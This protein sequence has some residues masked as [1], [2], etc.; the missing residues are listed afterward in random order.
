MDHK[1]V[2]K[3]TIFETIVGSQAYG[4]SNEF[5]DIDKAGVM[6]PGK[7]YFYSMRKF[8][9]FSDYLDEDKTI[10]DIRKAV[11]LI[12]DNNPNM[13]DLL[14]IPERCI[15]RTTKHWDLLRENRDLFVSKKCRY[16]FAGYAIAQLERIKT[17]RKFLLDPPKGKPE[18]ADF[19][20]KPTSIFPTA[21]LKAI[22]YSAIGD[23]L[24]QDSKEDFLAE[25]DGVYS[26]YIIP[27]FTKYIIESKRKLAI[28]YLQVGVKS[29]ANTLRALG[30]SYI[31]EEY[32]A[33]A[34]KELLFYHA[35]KEWERYVDWQKTRNVKRADLEAK[36][37]Y[38]TKH[39][40]HLIRL[41]RMALEIMET[42]QV[43]VDRTNIDAEELKAIRNGSMPFE[44]VEEYS[45]KVDLK[46]DE[47]YKSSKLQKSPKIEKIIDL[48]VKICDNYLNRI[49]ILTIFMHV[50]NKDFR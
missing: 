29:Q 6:I 23:F 9:Q 44:E 20:L 4:T 3:R 37:G 31:K 27:M 33:E 14:W 17:H 41:C 16:T 46:L 32:L 7:E 48:C 10:Y 12:A 49:D 25:L 1:Y 22:V 30:P 19:G 40:M 45:K 35:S 50:M 38:D 34:E 2:D 8:E 5:S 15:I 18:R 21:Q 36:F 24:I 47:L 28:E 39:A 13:M 11:T 26:D 43:N 42:G